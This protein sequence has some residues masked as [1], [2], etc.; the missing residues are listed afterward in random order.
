MS[1]EADGVREA[2]RVLRRLKAGSHLESGADGH[3][4]LVGRG[5]RRTEVAAS[6]TALLCANGWVRRENGILVIAAAGEGWLASRSEAFSGPDRILRTRRM[7]DERGR[8]CHV[9]VNEAESP[10]GWM[11][12]RG[13]VD[14]VQFE[15]G[16]RLRR[17]FTMAQLTPR[18]GVD[19]SAPVGRRSYKPETLLTETALAAKQRFNRAMRAAGPGLA[20]ILFDVCCYLRGLEESEQARNWPRASAKVVLRIAL[21]RLAEHYGMNRKTRSR[22]RAWKKEDDDGGE[23]Q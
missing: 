4:A 2:R 14:G 3:Y 6:L 22:L 21:D 20:D 5:G 7:L 8:E 17:D 13:L 15:A 1:P 10:L 18:L 23:D 12:K 11:H 16:E 19:F 9:V